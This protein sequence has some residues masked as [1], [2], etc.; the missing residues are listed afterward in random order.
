MFYKAAAEALPS[1][2]V[3][4]ML[5]SRCWRSTLLNGASTYQRRVASQATTPGTSVT[6]GVPDRNTND[7]ASGEQKPVSI[8]SVSDVVTTIESG[9]PESL[10]SVFTSN[11]DSTNIDQTPIIPDH[12]DK[13]VKDESYYLPGHISRKIIVKSRQKKQNALPTV[14]SKVVTTKN[15]SF[16]MDQKMLSSTAKVN[17]VFDKIISQDYTETKKI[18]EES[19]STNNST[20]ENVNNVDDIECD[21]ENRINPI[22]IQMLPRNIYDQIFKY[23]ISERFAQDENAEYSVHQSIKHLKQQKLW[24][25]TNTRQ[26]NIK[27]NLPNLRG[28]NL[29]EHFRIIAE[30]QCSVY[31]K[32][33]HDL[34]HNPLPSAPGQFA[35]REGWTKY[36]SDG[37]HCSVPVPDCN[38]YVFD[39]EVCVTEGSLPTLATAV[40]DKHWYS[41]CS[42][43]LINDANINPSL[44]EM[45]SCLDERSG[46]NLHDLIPFGGASYTDDGVH[47]AAKII[48][49]HNV[50]YDRVRIKEQYYIP[51]NP[52]RFIDTM[53]LHI[54]VSGLVQEQRALLMKNTKAEKKIH[55][56]WMSVGA[57]NNLNDVYKF[58]CK[59]N[60]LK[61]DTRDIFVSGSM[62]D[63]RSDFQNLMSYCATDVQA[64]H[65]V[66]VK[67][68]P[69]FYE[70]FPHP[71]TF[72]GILEMGSCFLPVNDN[73]EKYIE[74]SEATYKV[75]QSALTQKLSACAVD[76][77]TLLENQQY[78][79]DPWLWN[80]D[81]EI[82]KKY[83]NS[84]KCLPT[85]YVKLCKT[86]GEREGSPEP[87]NM[88]TSLRVVP[89]LLRLTWKGLPLHHEK[90]L[91][92]G[93]LRPT[94]SSYKKYCESDEH[95]KSTNFPLE[96]LYR[97]SPE[98]II[99]N[100]QLLDFY[101]PETEED[102]EQLLFG[103]KLSKTAA[104]S[105]SVKKQKSDDPEDWPIDIGIP[106]A[107]FI[108]LP[109]KN[110]PKNNV[111]KR[112]PCFSIVISIFIIPVKT[113]LN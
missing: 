64:T 23:S 3:S 2:R 12:G 25:K 52:I 86:T 106:G 105:K 94:H 40:S 98:R 16:R 82:P 47:H 111:G 5:Y 75:M 34:T 24:G 61:K 99:Q 17:D 67:L 51:D 57:L 63:I 74:S 29:N 33:L 93:Y 13:K 95:T 79:F 109:H 44:F 110:G 4:R 11:S 60:G 97:I 49:G 10:G 88:S 50:S 59:T 22:G 107:A 73:W 72:A 55:Q 84:D 48:V 26:Q 104:K 83:K 77:L 32:L 20:T 90:D 9:L 37:T 6:A 65:A 100:E 76:A 21:T 43:A 112:F 101:G 31:K 102:W 14:R 80:L 18:S 41:W 92:W 66:L 15:N 68:L 30:E 42:K 70:R 108:R 36:F 8:L 103:G 85:W 38:A 53:S 113:V 54:A 35:F 46:M 71:V 28:G 56:Q 7:G 45:N 96:E 89:K 87:D 27:L 58:Y 78:E 62:Q 91:G 39:V 1:C 69:M 19:L 81:W